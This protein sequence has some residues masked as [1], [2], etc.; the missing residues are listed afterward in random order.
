MPL[1]C[2]IVIR[3]CYRKNED[4]LTHSPSETGAS[5]TAIVW[6]SFL[7]HTATTNI[8]SSVKNA[9]NPVPESV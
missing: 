5:A 1:H 3:K 2:Q 8:S 4:N 9:S 7:I 6:N